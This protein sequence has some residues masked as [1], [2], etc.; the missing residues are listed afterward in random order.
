MAFCSGVVVMIDKRFISRGFESMYSY[1]KSPE[2]SN[3]VY[4]EAEER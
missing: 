4:I 2:M 3:N 1:P